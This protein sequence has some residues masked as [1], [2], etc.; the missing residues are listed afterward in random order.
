MNQ[1]KKSFGQ[2]FEN[3]KFL[4]VFS[5]VASM[6]CWLIVA[7]TF[8]PTREDIIRRVP[9][10]LSLQT[11]TL[12]NLGL[13]VIEGGEAYV[14]VKVKGSLTVIGRLSPEDI[15]ITARVTGITEPGPYSLD[16]ITVNQGTSLEYEIVEFVPSK[17]TVKLDRV[18]KKE[19]T[20]VDK[21]NGLAYADNFV[22][23]S[24]TIEPSKVTVTGPQTEIDKIKQCI[25][26]AELEG[27]LSETY[28]RELPLLFLDARGEEINL[29]AHHLKSDASEA[30]LVYQVLHAVDI[31]LLVDFTNVPR[32]FP[33]ERLRG[34]MEMD[35]HTL[36]VAGPGDL[37]NNLTER[38]LG[39]IDIATLRPGSSA[40]SFP[41][42]LPS[43]QLVPIE[44]FTNIN[45]TFD[46]SNWDSVVFSMVR[47]TMINIPPGYEATLLANAIY[48]IQMVGDAE[49]LAGVTAGDLVAEVDLSEREL[50]P[51]ANKLPVRISA[52]T[53]G[54]V[55]AVDEKDILV[56]IKEKT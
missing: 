9:V 48:N 7:M 20:I 17:I 29:E 38:V 15:P 30:L 45:V 51:G 8:G 2:L 46:D 35:H 11:T 14:D 34:L 6:L 10:N 19:F 56:D 33:V 4:M 42:T 49:D 55:W 40:Y 53:K 28:S 32:S 18:V 50:M 13:S 44:K 26:T 24:T 5:V 54:L 36:K 3:N 25:V 22:E 31:E 27:P 37:T 43:E 23:G 47:P 21:P 16:V 1:N 52:P 41:L 39:Y 12:S